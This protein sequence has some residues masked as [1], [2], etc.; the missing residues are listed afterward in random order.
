MITGFPTTV[1]P[2]PSPTLLP[3]I[4]K[5]MQVKNTIFPTTM[6]PSAYPTSLPTTN[7]PY[8]LSSINIPSQIPTPSP[9]LDTVGLNS[10]SVS[11]QTS[12][13]STTII[14]SIVASIVVLLLIIL[15]LSCFLRKKSEKMSPYE[16]WTTHYS[17]NKSLEPKNS[18]NE[19][20]HHFYSRNPRPSIHP[21]PVFTPHLSTNSSY[22]NSQVTGQRN[23][24]RMSI[25]IRKP[26]QQNYAL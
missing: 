18:T 3:S 12:S 6:R 14:A 22:R 11:N 26:I 19:D 7:R 8:V 13:S 16:L 10:G 5:K 15:F 4:P 25:P 2:S 17:S 9:S 20:I 21:N 1:R 23:S 24:L